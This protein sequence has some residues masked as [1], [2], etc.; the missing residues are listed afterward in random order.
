MFR[1]DMFCDNIF[2]MRAPFIRDEHTFHAPPP[3]GTTPLGALPPLRELKNNLKKQDKQTVLHL[4]L[5]RSI[6]SYLFL[7]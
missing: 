2:L 1:W 7:N 4:T 6:S 3:G 5:N